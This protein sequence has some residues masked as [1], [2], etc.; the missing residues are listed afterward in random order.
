[1]R[2]WPSKDCGSRPKL[3]E[4]GDSTDRGHVC[5]YGGEPVSPHLTTHRFAKLSR[6][7]G[8]GIRFHDLRH[9]PMSH[10]SAACVHPKV[11]SERAGHASVAITLDLQSHLILGIHEDAA[12][13]IDAGLGPCLDRPRQ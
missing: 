7:L 10:L 2:P 3:A 11:A 4:G 9:S 5:D 12:A 1:M 13:P 8:L 6:R